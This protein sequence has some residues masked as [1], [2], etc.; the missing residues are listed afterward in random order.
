MKRAPLTIITSE[1]SSFSM[2]FPQED[3][4]AGESEVRH[5]LSYSPHSVAPNHQRNTLSLTRSEIAALRTLLN[6]I[7]V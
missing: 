1:R 6:T 3:P 2:A 7:P 5:Q 4:K